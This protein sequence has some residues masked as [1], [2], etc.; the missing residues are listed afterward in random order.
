MKAVGMPVKP[1]IRSWRTHLR[2]EHVPFRKDCL[3]C[4]QAA[5]RKAH[6][7]QK[8]PPRAGVMSIDTAGPWSRRRTCGASKLGSFTGPDVP[9][10]EVGEVEGPV[11]EVKDKEVAAVGD[12][13]EQVEE[14]EEGREGRPEAMVLLRVMFK[15]Q[16]SAGAS[17]AK[18][19]SRSG[20][21]YDHRDVP[22]SPWRWICSVTARFR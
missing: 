20:A 4:Q 16:L 5:E 17:N 9:E 10:E 14:P 13:E 12:E 22:S 19:T 1:R 7:R 11:L 3:V 6:P 18:S 15:S 2:R 21:L 8:L